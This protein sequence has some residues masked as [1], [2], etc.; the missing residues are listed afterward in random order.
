MLFMSRKALFLCACVCFLLVKGKVLFDFA[1][2]YT[3]HD[4]CTLWHAA[5]EASHGKFHEPCF[6]GQSY[7]SNLEAWLAV[8]LLLLNIPVEQAVPLSTTLLAA[9]IFLLPATGLAVRKR[10][11]AAWCFLFAGLMMPAEMHLIYSMPRGFINGIFLVALGYFLYLVIRGKWR[12]FFLFMLMSL[13]FWINPNSVVFSAAIVLFD[14]WYSE[15]KKYLLAITGA[16]TGTLYK[17]F[18]IWFYHQHPLY[19]YHKKKILVFEWDEWFAR[20]T[21][22]DQ[23]FFNFSWLLIAVFLMSVVLLWWQKKLRYLFATSLFL[24]FFLLTLSLERVGDG[25]ES[26]YYHHS[27]MYLALPLALGLLASAALSDLSVLKRINLSYLATTAGILLT[28]WQWKNI[29]EGIANEFRK[30]DHGVQ[31]EAVAS[32]LNRFEHIPV[33]EDQ[34]APELVVFAENCN[35]C[36]IDTYAIPALSDGKMETINL[37]ED[38]RGWRFEEELRYLERNFFVMSC[39]DPQQVMLLD[40]LDQ[41]SNKELITG[42]YFLH[43]SVSVPE[44]FR[45]LLKQL[46]YGY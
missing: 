19:D 41:R 42:C 4:Q 28:I 10:T 12:H 29:R 7:N 8:P 6:Y 35:S 38:R 5:V 44:H 36:W 45:P 43:T 32:V 3:D 34:V 14:W 24:V 21:H 31:V 9:L 27:R 17:A 46:R 16:L 39:G 20:I 30:G 11:T 22:L 26:I 18:T 15:E 23:Y 33:T 37:R 13:G 1:W 2:V 25:M 40:S